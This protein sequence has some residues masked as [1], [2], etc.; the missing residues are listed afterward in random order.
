M[1]SDFRAPPVTNPATTLLPISWAKAPAIICQWLQ[2][3]N[4]RLLGRVGAD[5]P[6]K[7]RKFEAFE[8]RNLVLS[9]RELVAVEKW[10]ETDDALGMLQGSHLP[11][12]NWESLLPF[13]PNSVSRPS[14]LP[15]SGC[16]P[17]CHVTAIFSSRS[18]FQISIRPAAIHRDTLP[19]HQGPPNSTSLICCP[20]ASDGVLNHIQFSPYE[21]TNPHE[22][23]SWAVAKFVRLFW[24][25][26][27][28]GATSTHGRQPTGMDMSKCHHRPT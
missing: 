26:Y 7:P 27:E 3:A 23:G 1:I 2:Q 21:Y 16:P 5:M 20:L 19:S 24:R 28:Y 12:S 11:S 6:Q 22:F 8:V 17:L 15:G 13:S 18:H 9:C 14:R 4:I 10:E 25:R